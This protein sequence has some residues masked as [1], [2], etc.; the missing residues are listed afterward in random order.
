MFYFNS[1]WKKDLVSGLK[2]TCN[3]R[4]THTKKRYMDLMNAADN[5]KYQNRHLEDTLMI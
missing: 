4:L 1:A 2:R 3:K 5:L